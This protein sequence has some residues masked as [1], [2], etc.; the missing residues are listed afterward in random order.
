VSADCH[1]SARRRDED[2]VLL[3][4]LA[5][6][7]LLLLMMCMLERY[8]RLIEGPSRPELDDDGLVASAATHARPSDLAAELGPELAPEAA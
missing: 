7:A 4:L 8:E 2:H 6:P 1:H 3:L 5:M